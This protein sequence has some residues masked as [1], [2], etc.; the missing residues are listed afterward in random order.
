[1]AIY[2]FHQQQPVSIDL[3][4]SFQMS[5]DVQPMFECCCK[6]LFHYFPV[7][8]NFVTAAFK[9]THSNFNRSVFILGQILI[10]I[11]ASPIY[12]IALNYLDENVKEVYSSTYHGQCSAK[13]CNTNPRDYGRWIL[14][15]VYENRNLSNVRATSIC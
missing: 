2:A 9:S 11:G 10:G 3:S 12:T 8:V 14:F 7:I 13:W 1:M 6:S 5:L 15:V 4:M